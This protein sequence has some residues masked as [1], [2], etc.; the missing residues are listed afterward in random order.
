ML[1]AGQ[2]AP[3]GATGAGST[4]IVAQLL[5]HETLD[6]AAV[7]AAAGLTPQ[8]GAAG[9]A[10]HAAAQAAAHGGS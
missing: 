8:P 10:A 9:T 7:Y 3:A 4:R 5:E 6:E 2:R 1:P